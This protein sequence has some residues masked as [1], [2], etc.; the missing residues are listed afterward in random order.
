M[1]KATVILRPA[2][3]ESSAGDELLAI[4][5]MPGH[6]FEHIS[7]FLK[8]PGLK[9]M[10]LVHKNTRQKVNR[11]KIEIIFVNFFVEN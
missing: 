7:R 8:L 9:F 1:K 5:D 11:S 6:V 3:S 10:P 4:G 2:Q